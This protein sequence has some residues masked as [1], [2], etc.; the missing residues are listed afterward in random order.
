MSAGFRQHVQTAPCPSDSESDSEVLC[1]APSSA[2]SDSDLSYDVSPQQP[3]VL[4]GEAAE[5][6]TCG[7]RGSGR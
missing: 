3:R 1:D 7:V 4:P 2:G 6:A 5:A